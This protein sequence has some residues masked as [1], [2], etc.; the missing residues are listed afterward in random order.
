[1]KRLL[2]FCATI[3]VVTA[4]GAAND[5]PKRASTTFD[6][7][8]EMEVL[9]TTEDLD[10]DSSLDFTQSGTPALESSKGNALFDGR[11]GNCYI[12]SHQDSGQGNVWNR[13]G[14]TSQTGFTIEARIRVSVHASAKYAFALAASLP[15]SNAYALLNFSTNCAM[16]GDIVLTNIDMRASMHTW[17]IA[18]AA[19]SSV[20]SV[21]CDGNLVEKNLSGASPGYNW[22]VLIGQPGVNWRGYAQVAYLRFTK[23]GYAPTIQQKDSTEFAHRYEMDSTDTRFSPTENATDWNHLQGTNGDSVL[24]NGLLSVVQPTG[25][26]RYWQTT[27]PM[28]S[29]ITVT[30][31]FTLEMKVRVSD[32]W[33]ANK[34]VLNLLCGTPRASGC[35]FIGTNSVC[36]YNDN[37]V[38]WRGDNTDKTHVFRIAYDGDTEWGFTLWRDGELIGQNLSNYATNGDRNYVR[39][40]IVSQYSHGGSFEVDYI[41]WTTDGVFA[42]YIPPQGTMMIFR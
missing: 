27:D 20:Y 5:L 25:S 26:M 29:S 23:G 41:R 7:R 24:A 22:G 4:F 6:F 28:D 15:D 11:E 1:M 21:W 38:I 17:R 8:Y 19:G 42:P 33:Y 39:F 32:A 37:N 31:P 35:F 9:P 34:P 16:W 13:Y 30:S 40:G 14:V 36:W 18:R 12:Q 3:A 10:G 2:N